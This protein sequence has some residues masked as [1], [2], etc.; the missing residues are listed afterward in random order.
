MNIKT[1]DKGS[2]L[3]WSDSVV[4]WFWFFSD[5]GGAEHGGEAEEPAEAGEDPAV[6]PSVHRRR[7]PAGPAAHAGQL[8][9]ER[10]I[11]SSF[12]LLWF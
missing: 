5:D 10:D 6:E 12:T 11:I 7:Q 4:L 2:D 8:E 3:L 9:P 1:V